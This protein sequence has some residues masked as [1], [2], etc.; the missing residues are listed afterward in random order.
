[1]DSRRP[2]FPV[3]PQVLDQ[4]LSPRERADARFRSLVQN[5][6]DII[7]VLG[8]D[9]MIQYESP[10]TERI[11]G[12][13]PEQLVGHNA[14][15]FV[16]PEDIPAVR[17]A[18]MAAISEPG[19]TVSPE[20]RFRHADGSWVFLEAIGNNLLADPEINGLVITSR[21]VTARRALE[22]QLRQAQ[23][24]EAIGQLAGGI[25]HDFNNMLMIIRGY[26]ELMLDQIGPGQPLRTSAVNILKTTDRASSLTNRLLAFSRK[27]AFTPRV[28]DVEALVKE[29]VS[30]LPQLLGPDIDIS[31]VSPSQPGLIL[32]DP[33]QL[34]QVIMNL[35]VNS[36]DA[37]PQ[38][39]KLEIKLSNVT[40]NATTAGAQTWIA[41]GRY[42]MLTVSDTGAGMDAQTQDHMFEPFFTTKEKGKGTGLGL[43]IVYGIVKQNR[44]QILV[45]SEI[46]KGST[47]QIYLPA[48]EEPLISAKQIKVHKESQRGA[49]TVLLAEDE[50]CIRHLV[51]TFLEAEGYTVFPARDG[52]EAV[53]LAEQHVGPIDI[54]LTDVMMP[55]MRGPQLASHLAPVR[56]EMKVVYMSG[57]T[58]NLGQLDTT[59]GSKT[60]LLRKPFQLS[61]LARRLQEVLTP[62]Q[63]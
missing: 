24:M 45:S 48:V 1:M 23:K 13:T 2:S 28:L 56:P 36:R 59:S 25:A 53:Q 47:F 37:M 5:I 52:I 55:R 19:L 26:A 33:T 29:C 54:L 50:E 15:E 42:I 32:I 11:L 44:G 3:N 14:F 51:G 4:N 40:I 61:E 17:A 57:Y 43:A 8:V 34:E 16:H 31:I 62:V 21:D 20:F 35:A 60:T 7:T 63:A 12:F 27:E 38:G 18:F 41:P 58:E 22:E 49:G 9:G 46:G 30:M 39:G 6:S 10:S